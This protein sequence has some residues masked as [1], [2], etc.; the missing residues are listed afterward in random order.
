MSYFVL[1]PLFWGRRPIYKG[2]A[3]LESTPVGNSH[4]AASHPFRGRCA[5]H[6]A[7]SNRASEKSRSR[8]F[9]TIIHPND[10]P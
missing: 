6:S 4:D 5:F 9:S 7:A 8:A 2:F 3:A 10:F 1:S